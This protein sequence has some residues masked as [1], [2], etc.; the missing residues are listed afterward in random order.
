MPRTL[1]ASWARRRRLRVRRQWPRPFSAVLRRHNRA[2]SFYWRRR[3]RGSI[4]A[5]VS[6]TGEGS[7][8][9]KFRVWSCGSRVPKNPKLETRNS[10]LRGTMQQKLQVDKWLFSAT[11]GLALFGVVMVYSASAIIAVQENHSQFHYVMV[12]SASAI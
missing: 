4:S 9:K 2:T 5:R 10:N 7:L 6:N 3:V 8:K 11:V 1:N 12:Y